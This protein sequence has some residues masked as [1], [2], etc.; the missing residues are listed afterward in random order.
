M[1][2]SEKKY[3]SAKNVQNPN[4]PDAE[5]H[6]KAGKKVKEFLT[7][8]TETCDE[9]DKLSLITCVEPTIFQYCFHTRNN[10]TRCRT[11]LKHKM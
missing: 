10:K 1:S 5:Y 8:N 7:N 4:D 11:P 2:V 6:S 3:I 9:A